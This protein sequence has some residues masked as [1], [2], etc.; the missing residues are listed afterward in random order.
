MIG[1][2]SYK[3]VQFL[4]NYVDINGVKISIVIRSRTARNW[5]RKFGY[6]YKDVYKDVL[7]NWHEWPDVVED[8]KA[9]LEKM[10]ELKPYMVE[11]NKNG[12]IKPKVYSSDCKIGGNNWWPIIVITHN[13]CTFST[14]NEIWKVWARKGDTF[15]RPK[16]RGQGIMVSE[17]IFPYGRLN[18]ASF[19][20]K[21]REEVVQQTGLKIT[22]AVEIFEYGKNNNGYW[23]GAKLYKQIVEKALPVAEAL[24]PGYSLCFLFDNATNHF[25]Y[26]KNALQIKD[27]NKRLGRK[28]PILCNG[29]FDHKGIRI[30]YPMTFFNEKGKVTQ[31][32]VQKV[33][34]KRGILPTSGLNLMLS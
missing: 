1:L 30:T 32:N 17:F 5:L 34:E 19:T 9:F 29:W 24:Y 8:C 25:V 12:A 2:N 27:M 23:D 11:F 18:L 4:K 13:E 22:E 26:A 7:I 10:E 21:K 28:Q 33:L 6:E 20:P 15:L 3:L 14:N 16:S 31:K